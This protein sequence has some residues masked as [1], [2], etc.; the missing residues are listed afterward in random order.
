M[1]NLEAPGNILGTFVYTTEP[2]IAIHPVR[3]KNLQV[4]I[5]RENEEHNIR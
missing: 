1:Y 2:G 4:W 5:Q 3:N